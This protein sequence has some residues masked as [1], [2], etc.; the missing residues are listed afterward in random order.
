MTQH[1]IEPFTEGALEMLVT[2][3]GIEGTVVSADEVPRAEIAASM[4][5]EGQPGGQLLLGFSHEA[6]TR[7]VGEMLGMEPDELEEDDLADGIGEM[8]N[9]IAGFAKTRL[10]EA[11]V[12]FNLA[13]PE[14]LAG[15]ELA[16]H[17][18]GKN[19]LLGKLQT[20]YGDFDVAVWFA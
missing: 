1:L 7:L 11:G 17:M 5:L 13:L 4:P 9:I 18:D 6:A 14:I 20:E 12:H 2:M 8:A 10:S 15:D 19:V 3:L 16:S